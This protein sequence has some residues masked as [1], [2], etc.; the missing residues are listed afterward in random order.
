MDTT[1][2][3]AELI[4]ALRRD[5]DSLR[6]D[7]A[8]LRQENATIRQK[9]AAL[10]QQVAD[11]PPRWDNNSSNSSKPPSSDGLKKPP[12]VLK[13]LRGRSGKA[14]GGQVGH[15]GDTLRPMDKPDRIE[16][17]AAP[18]C[19]HCEACLP[20]A[21]VMGVERRQVFD[22]PQPRLEVTEHRASVYRCHHCS[23]VTKAAFPDAVTAHVQ[24]GP[25]LRAAAV[26]LNVQQLIPEDR[27]CEAVAD[28]FAA[29][30]LCPASVVA[31]T[32]K[33]AEAQ[34]PVVAHIAAQVV[35]AKV[36]H[37][38]WVRGVEAHEANRIGLNRLTVVDTGAVKSTCA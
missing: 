4:D 24:Y 20:A 15:K 32:A 37:L 13:S 29:A 16:C 6:A 27:V 35:A 9:N 31:W 26:Y 22:L 12:R 18:A 1:P 28:L 5:V 17:H 25:R 7:N 38:A 33:A 2:T 19:R 36:R 21:M 10:K 30:S 11:L 14:S 34:A 3:L 8:A 23:G